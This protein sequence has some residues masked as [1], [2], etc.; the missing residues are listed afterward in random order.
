[1]Y[2]ALNLSLLVGASPGFE[3]IHVVT[4]ITGSAAPIGSALPRL[5]IVLLQVFVHYLRRQTC[6][7]FFKL[8]LPI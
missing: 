6:C 4:K 1:M 3:E 7:C 8:V 2:K 5:L